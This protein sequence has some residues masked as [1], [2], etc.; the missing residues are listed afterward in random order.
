MNRMA[1]G[2]YGTVYQPIVVTHAKSR[3][4]YIILGLFFGCLGIHNFYAGRNGVGVAQLLI[5]IFSRLAANRYCYNSNL[6]ID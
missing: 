5:T 4:V 6:G 3:G 2:G 1:H